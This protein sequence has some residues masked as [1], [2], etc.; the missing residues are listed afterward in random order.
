M[1]AKE[2]VSLQLYTP[3]M[4]PWNIGPDIE[5]SKLNFTAAGI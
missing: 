5:M 3:D 4:C 1:L 2:V